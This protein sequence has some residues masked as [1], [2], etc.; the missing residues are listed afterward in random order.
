MFWFLSALCGGLT[1]ASVVAHS[2]TLDGHIFAF[3]ATRYSAV[4]AMTFFAF[5]EGIGIGI[6]NNCRI[7]FFVRDWKSISIYAERKSLHKCHAKLQIIRFS[8]Q[9]ITA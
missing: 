6:V 1:F 4:L 2:T 5:W 3:A 8:I 7:Y 9:N